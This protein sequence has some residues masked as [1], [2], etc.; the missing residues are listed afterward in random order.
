MD[1]RGRRSPRL[2]ID[3]R[4]YFIGPCVP[5]L[6]SP[7]PSLASPFRKSLPSPTA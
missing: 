7:T 2:L 1:S 3:T 6:F 4:A 5:F